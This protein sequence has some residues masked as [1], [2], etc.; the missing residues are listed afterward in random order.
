MDEA[1]RVMHLAEARIAYYEE[2]KAASVPDW[3]G[4]H[5]P[6]PGHA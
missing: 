1:D 3:D 2:L 4:T 6:K 5:I